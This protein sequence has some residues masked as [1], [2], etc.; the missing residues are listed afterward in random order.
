[1]EDNYNE[2]AH[3]LLRKLKININNI[4]KT[5]QTIKKIKTL[6]KECKEQINNYYEKDF[7]LFNY[8]S[9]S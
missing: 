1:M 8:K 9:S 6:S 7:Q 5:N 4:P 3:L 2:S